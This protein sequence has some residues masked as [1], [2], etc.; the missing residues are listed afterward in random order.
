MRPHYK[1]LP[2]V[3]IPAIILNGAGI[4]DYEKEEMVWFNSIKESAIEIV[5]DAM[6]K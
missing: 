5:R 1:K 6:K 4:Y 3:K 2:D